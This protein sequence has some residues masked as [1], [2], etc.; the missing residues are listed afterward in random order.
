MRFLI[1]APQ[2]YLQAVYGKHEHLRSFALSRGGSVKE[3]GSTRFFTKGLLHARLDDD[4]VYLHQQNGGYDRRQERGGVDDFSR[5]TKRR[6]KSTSVLPLLNAAS[7]R[8]QLI[9]IDAW[10][11]CQVG[12]ILKL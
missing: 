3:N 11:W 1:P 7:V 2:T 4:C 8:V 5:R 9:V 12:G 10:K 6:V